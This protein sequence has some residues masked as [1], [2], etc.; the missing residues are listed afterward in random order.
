LL[1]RDKLQALF[2]VSFR[3]VFAFDIILHV[4]VRRPSDA[5]AKEKLTIAN[6]SDEKL[7]NI[8]GQLMSTYKK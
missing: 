2:P 3:L 8:I 7:I 6:V 5:K 1:K 4:F